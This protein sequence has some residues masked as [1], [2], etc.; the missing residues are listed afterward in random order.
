[1]NLTRRNQRIAEY[2]KCQMEIL[3]RKGADYSGGRE[4]EDGNANFSE[5]ARRL[6]G[7][8]L[9][10]LTVWAVYFEKQVIAIETFIK[11]R[12]VESEGMAERFNDI[13]NY[14]NI[15]HTIFEEGI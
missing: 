15:R 3:E 7:V 13:A 9:D 6:E 1:M 2:C 10:K 8:P 5:V 12:H 11:T 14:A 4:S